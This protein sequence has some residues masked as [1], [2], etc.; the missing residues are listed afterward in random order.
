MSE[1]K[2]KAK[3]QPAGAWSELGNNPTW[4]IY[5]IFIYTN[6]N[7]DRSIVDVC[8][9]GEIILSTNFEGRI[10]GFSSVS[11][12][13]SFVLCDLA[14][15]SFSLSLLL[16]EYVQPSTEQENGLASE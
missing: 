4:A 10:L 7:V 3:A 5:I 14:W 2:I 11:W 9:F 15:C 8:G 1:L 6:L 16:V 12:L 13:L